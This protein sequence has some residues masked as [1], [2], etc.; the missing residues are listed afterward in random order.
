MQEVGVNSQT[1]SQIEWAYD[2]RR[3]N[4]APHPAQLGNEPKSRR[5]S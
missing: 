4:R 1:R 5:H 3:K 2:A